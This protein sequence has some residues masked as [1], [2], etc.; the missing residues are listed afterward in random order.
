MSAAVLTV[1]VSG[2]AAALAQALNSEVLPAGSVAVM[3]TAWPA[4]SALTRDAEA[5]VAARVGAHVIGPDEGLTLAEARAVAGSAGEDLD[6]EGGG[7]GRVQR[8]RHAA[9][10][11]RG[12]DREVLEVVGPLIGVIRIVGA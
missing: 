9:A 5:G 10:G 6:P 2:S 8:A 11:G 12:Q 4:L 7:G 3:V 1:K